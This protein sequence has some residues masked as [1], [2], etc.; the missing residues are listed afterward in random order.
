MGLK[1]VKK[2]LLIL[3]RAFDITMTITVIF[4]L[5][6]QLFDYSKTNFERLKRAQSHSSYIDS[7][8]SMT[9]THRSLG[10]S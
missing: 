8:V 1:F 2:D 3:S 4:F 10:A 9:S 5:F 7:C 6:Y